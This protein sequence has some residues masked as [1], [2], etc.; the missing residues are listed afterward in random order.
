M[1]RLVNTSALHHIR[2]KQTA[3]ARMVLVI[4]LTVTILASLNLFGGDST[5]DSSRPVVITSSE[6]APRTADQ[7]REAYGRI[8]LSFE[9][10]HGQAGEAANYVARG[11]GYTLALSPTEA[12]FALARKSGEPSRG[13]PRDPDA[14]KRA[15]RDGRVPDAAHS[16]QSAVLRMNLVGANRGARVAGQD[17]LEAKVNY[18][19]GNDPAKWRANIPTYRARALCGSLSGH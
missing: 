3:L 16:D 17:E 9:A 15:K 5:P 10:N 6:S 14:G 13:N 1:K 8:P 4:A 18:F 11:A 12:V 19:I 7:V 2:H